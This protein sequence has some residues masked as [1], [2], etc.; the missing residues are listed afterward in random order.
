[1]IKKYQVEFIGLME[2]LHTQR[3]ITQ[4]MQSNA[5]DITN[6]ERDRLTALVNRV[7]MRL[8]M[9]EIEA[10]DKDSHEEIP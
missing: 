10:L 7:F 2:L 6:D 3:A 9:A 1:M 5:N 4:Y 8:Q